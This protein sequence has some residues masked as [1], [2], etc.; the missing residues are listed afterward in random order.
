MRQLLIGAAVIFGFSI[1]PAAAKSVTVTCSMISGYSDSE[2]GFW[3]FEAKDRVGNAEADRLYG[4][5]HHLRD[6]CGVNPKA[7]SNVN[8][9][10]AK[11]QWMAQ[12][13]VNL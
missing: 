4:A 9:S 1:A 7:I 3:Y 6:R 2:V 5:F 8:I 13:G 12:E 11:Q 10:P